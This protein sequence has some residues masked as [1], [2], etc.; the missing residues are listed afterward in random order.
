MI[1]YVIYCTASYSHTNNSEIQL[2]LYKGYIKG[3]VQYHTH[4]IM[5]HDIK[6]NVKGE[7]N[8]YE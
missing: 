8:L 5:F 2:V 3:Q 7:G 6:D 4:I 1:Q